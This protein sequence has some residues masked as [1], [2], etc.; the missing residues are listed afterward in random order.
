MVDAMK[1][2][3]AAEAIRALEN[4][5]TELDLGGT[6][7]PAS[8][9]PRGCE[10]A[11]LSRPADNG[12]GVKG[13]R[14][15]AGALEKNATLVGALFTEAGRGRS[16]GCWSRR[17]VALTVA[18]CKLKQVLSTQNGFNCVGSAI[19]AVPVSLTGVFDALLAVH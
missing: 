12:I 2:R 10:R 11:L 5:A 4:G 19:L 15:M 14:A 1:V 13:A 9:T 17:A 3:S 18:M 8:R 16:L 7:R 6:F